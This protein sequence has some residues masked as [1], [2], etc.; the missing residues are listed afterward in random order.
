MLT[1]PLSQLSIVAHTSNGIKSLTRTNNIILL[2][3]L[4]F[5]KRV[6]AVETSENCL[7][8]NLQ[9]LQTSNNNRTREIQKKQL[10]TFEK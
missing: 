10:K 3:Y 4:F 2:F 9:Q 6:Q 8:F 5:I 7:H 1:E